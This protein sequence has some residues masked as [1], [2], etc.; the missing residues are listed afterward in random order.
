MEKVFLNTFLQIWNKK[1]NVM[2]KEGITY[3]KITHSLFQH[4]GVHSAAIGVSQT[5]HLQVIGLMILYFSYARFKCVLEN[6]VY[7]CKYLYMLEY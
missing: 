2:C 5:I 1:E 7:V 3:D 6:A 4:Q